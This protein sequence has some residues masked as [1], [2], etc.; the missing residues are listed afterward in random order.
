MLKK[1]ILAVSLAIATTA[2][3]QQAP[4]SE[5]G[6][7]K[8][9]N[10]TP[11]Y[12][13]RQFWNNSV[14]LA[15]PKRLPA[16]G[17]R[18]FTI[19]GGETMNPVSFGCEGFDINETAGQVVQ[20]FDRLMNLDFAELATGL[21]WYALIYMQ[22]TVYQGI[23]DFSEKLK[24]GL[25]VRVASCNTIR[26]MAD[27]STKN[28]IQK[29]M[30]ECRRDGKSEADCAVGETL[31]QYEDRVWD[32]VISNMVQ[33]RGP[34]SKDNENKSSSNEDVSTTE[35]LLSCVGEPSDDVK[36]I[37]A[38]VPG[39]KYS[40]EDGKVLVSRTK[41]I[42]EFIVAEAQRQKE[43]VDREIER[44]V[45]RP[46]T[47]AIDRAL[48]EIN[49]SGSINEE[50]VSAQ[51]FMALVEMKKDSPANY[52]AAA[53]SLAYSRAL[54]RATAKVKAMQLAIGHALTSES[55]A[56][57]ILAEDQELIKRSVAY[58][59]DELRAE[60]EVQKRREEQRQVMLSIQ[61][62]A[63]KKYQRHLE[64]V[65]DSATK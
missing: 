31:Q 16:S 13:D 63:E 45:F 28:V 60:A 8:E 41:T 30:D 12:L 10:E 35:A 18:E 55:C 14:V 47:E 20:E 38:Y 3:A 56:N 29:A 25:Q 11:W 32:D 19:L 59:D 27:A 24:T 53:T 21:A 65:R 57:V 1:S 52:D 6:S 17:Y 43:I 50:F 15:G 36:D 23:E 7:S 34:G 26:Q 40:T 42:R 4:Q 62:E 46:G 33:V 49:A 39:T 5:G 51:T 61:E 64:A 2:F 44:Y 22:P 48:A 54:V 37:A 9:E 58:L